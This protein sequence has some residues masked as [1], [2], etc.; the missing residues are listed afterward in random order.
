MEG[1]SEKEVRLYL[2]PFYF[3]ECVFFL[4][5]YSWLLCS[6]EYLEE[7]GLFHITQPRSASAGEC[8]WFLA[9]STCHRGVPPSE[10]ALEANK[11]RRILFWFS[12]ETQSFPEH[13]V[14]DVDFQLNP[15]TICQILRRRFTE[16][17]V[18][19]F[20]SFSFCF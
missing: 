12:W 6:P 15:W 11:E 7:S 5:R 17:L 19:L 10:K 9:D 4:Q 13:I 14:P 20:L 18:G 2:F 3:T 1:L 16:S 8:A